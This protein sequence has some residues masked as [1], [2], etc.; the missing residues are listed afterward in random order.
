MEMIGLQLPML[1]PFLRMQTRLLL[2]IRHRRPRN[3][4]CPLRRRLH[5][6]PV[7]HIHSHMPF[8]QKNL[9]TLQRRE[10]RRQTQQCP[11]ICAPVM[12]G[13]PP[14]RNPPKPPSVHMP[15]LSG[16]SP[17]NP[18]HHPRLVKPEVVLPH[19]VHNHATRLFV[20]HDGIASAADGSM[21]SSQAS[22]MCSA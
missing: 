7:P 8:L 10:H 9:P 13:I 19:H 4:V 2:Q 18:R 3:T 17:Q 22:R 20:Y 5:C 1:L 21:S 15:A 12:S 11:A 16:P 14:P 6:H